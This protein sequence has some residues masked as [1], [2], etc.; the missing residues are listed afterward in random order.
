MPGIKDVVNDQQPV[1][2]SHVLD[3]VVHTVYGNIYGLI[4]YAGI[5][6]CPNSDVV[7]DNASVRQELLN[8]YA[9][10]CCCSPQRQDEDR[11]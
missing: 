9:E 11:M 3:Q 2:V 7:G 1:F 10:R 5:G 4:V 6:R 8:G